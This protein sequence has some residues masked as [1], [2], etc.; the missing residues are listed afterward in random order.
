VVCHFRISLDR[1]IRAIL[2]RLTNVIISTTSSKSLSLNVRRGLNFLSLLMG[3]CQFSFTIFVF[4]LHGSILTGYVKGITDGISST[5]GRMIFA[6][7]VSRRLNF[8]IEPI[9]AGISACFLLE[10][11]VLLLN[12]LTS[13]NYLA[14]V[15]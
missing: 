7:D 10:V 5:D 11:N 14:M 15:I 3:Q 13:I 9:C 1:F 6:P 2:E 8:F 12:T 4:A